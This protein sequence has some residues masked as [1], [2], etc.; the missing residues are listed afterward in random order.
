[1][2]APTT[3]STSNDEALSHIAAESVIWVRPAAARKAIGQ[4][5]DD[6]EQM[7]LDV[8]SAEALVEMPSSGPVA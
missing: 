8:V 1:V 5:T 6:W 3:P 4:D 2:T 7:M